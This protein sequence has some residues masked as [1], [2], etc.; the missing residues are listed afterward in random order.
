MK[1]TVE[2]SPNLDFDSNFNIMIVQ[3]NIT[4]IDNVHLKCDCIDGSLIK[5]IKQPIFSVLH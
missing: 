2:L 5:G 3:K 1:T 4:T